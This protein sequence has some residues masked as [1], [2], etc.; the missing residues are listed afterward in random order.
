MKTKEK[1]EIIT[2]FI[3][4]KGRG[5]EEIK[6]AQATLFILQKRISDIKIVTGLSKRRAYEV[7][8]D[9]EEIGIKAFI[10]KRKGKPKELLNKKQKE[11][12]VEILKTKIPGD[13]NLSGDHWTT[14]VLADYIKVKYNVKYKSKTSYYL[15]F[16]QASFSF[17]LPGKVYEKYDEEKTKKWRKEVKPLLNKAFEDKNTVILCEDEMIL[18]S[19]TTLQKI[20]LPKRSY[21]KIEINQKKENRSFYGFLN[22][23]TGR[24]HVYKR[25]RQNMYITAEILKRIR[26]LYKDKKILILWDGAGWHRGSKVQEFIEKD[27]N[28]KTIYFPPYS[29]EEN[30]QEHVWKEGRSKVT[31]NKFIKNI[32]KTADEFVKY[33]R[34]TKFN[35]VLSAVC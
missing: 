19:Q 21:P 6:R 25:E 18:S 13:L 30:P 4:E 32:D 35:Y 3:Q 1:I 17:H 22:M 16:K 20:W 24:Q 15:I 5:G 26:K 27:K 7:K 33:L 2:K 10:D 12:I 34:K 14:S 23:E 8:S 31:H 11:E 29:P 9:F 28:I